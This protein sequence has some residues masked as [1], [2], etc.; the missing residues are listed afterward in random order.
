MSEIDDLRARIEALEALV[1]KQA[2]SLQFVRV[3]AQITRRWLND[4]VR[5]DENPGRV[6]DD[7]IAS[8]VPPPNLGQ[9]GKD[10]FKDEI[11]L[12]KTVRENH[13]NH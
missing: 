6:T 4:L 1:T 5:T 8:A 9:T 13:P 10:V 2:A 3:N 11:E 7:V 12:I